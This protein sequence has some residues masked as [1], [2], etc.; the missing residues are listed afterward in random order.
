MV[1]GNEYQI[2]DMIF[3]FVAVFIFWATWSARNALMAC[4]THDVLRACP[5]PD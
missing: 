3:L 4:C 1:E 5:R 2:D